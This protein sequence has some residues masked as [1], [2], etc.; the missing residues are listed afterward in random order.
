MPATTL[1]NRALIAVAGEEAEDFLQGIITTDVPGI[2]AGEA[3]SGALLT[4]QGKR[5]AQNVS[6]HSVWSQHPNVVHWG[7]GK[8]TDVD[9]IEVRWPNG[10]LTRLDKPAADKYHDAK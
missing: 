7:L 5:V 2:G 4:P 1:A 3:Y 10:E 6:G 9:A 8:S